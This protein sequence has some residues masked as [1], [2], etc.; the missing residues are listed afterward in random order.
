MFFPKMFST[1]FKMFTSS[2]DGAVSPPNAP[3]SC[4][5]AFRCRYSCESLTTSLSE[6]TNTCMHSWQE[7]AC[8]RCNFLTRYP[9]MYTSTFSTAAPT[10]KSAASMTCNGKQGVFAG[11]SS[12][13]TAAGRFLQV[14]RE[15]EAK[16]LSMMSLLPAQLDTGI[17][18]ATKLSKKYIYFI[19]KCNLL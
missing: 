1:C 18:P 11:I 12:S 8:D 17:E 9:P 10:S 2:V 6:I 13:S 16:L 4:E 14:S 3:F 19:L 5:Y 7:K 15:R